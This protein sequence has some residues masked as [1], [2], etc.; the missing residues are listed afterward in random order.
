MTDLFTH[1][2]RHALNLPVGDVIRNLIDLKKIFS[3]AHEISKLVKRIT[4]TKHKAGSNSKSTKN[5]SKEI[6]TFC[7]TRRTVLGDTLAELLITT[8]D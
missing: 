1:C 2:Y 5:E 6:H 8:P 3:A 4:K 7:P